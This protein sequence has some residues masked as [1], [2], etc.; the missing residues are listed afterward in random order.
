MASE[1]IFCKIANREMEAEIV[2][3]DDEI[4]AFKDIHPAAPV[5]ILAIPKKHIPSHQEIKEE[6]TPLVGKIHIILRELAQAFEVEQEGYRVVVNCGQH[7]GQIVYH[8]HFHLLGGR[9]LDTI[10]GPRGG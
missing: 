9:P 6:D 8:L 7:A 2:Y 10:A 4:M 5:H 3:E 1:C